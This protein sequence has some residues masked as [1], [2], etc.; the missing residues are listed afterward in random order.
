MSLHPIAAA[1][2][3]I[4]P[5]QFRFPFPF[6]PPTCYKETKLA[7]SCWRIAFKSF[8]GLSPVQVRLGEH[9]DFGEGRKTTLW[10]CSVSSWLFKIDWT[11]FP[12][13]AKHWTARF[14][15]LNI[16]GL[17]YMCWWLSKYSTSFTKNDAELKPKRSRRSETTA[18]VCFYR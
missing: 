15:L 6:S 17:P 10:W 4:A 8:P 2:V 13:P 3:P 1:E 7:S 14:S 12:C 16:Y 11:S 9:W 5:K 18:K